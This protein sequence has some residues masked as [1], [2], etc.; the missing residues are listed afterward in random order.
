[1]VSQLLLTPNFLCN[2]TL[3][4][5]IF[6][7]SA[8]FNKNNSVALL[9]RKQRQIKKIKEKKRPQPTSRPRGPARH[10]ASRPG[11]PTRTTHAAE[12]IS[13]PLGLG[14]VRPSYL[15]L[16]RLSSSRFS[17]P[18]RCRRRCRGY[19]P[20][21]TTPTRPTAPPASSTSATSPG[22][23]SE[24]AHQADRSLPDSSPFSNAAALIVVFGHLDP[25]RAH[26]R[27]LQHRC[28]APLV[29]PIPSP[30]NP[31]S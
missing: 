28:E 22:W 23:S 12:G 7:Q 1:M 9:N 18:E 17:L 26:C 16:A 30:Q 29:F 15:P 3:F 14:L 8:T 4:L 27:P 11:R 31:S 25:S 13:L 6:V 20:S 2:F 5:S 24:S 21:L 10:P 19:D